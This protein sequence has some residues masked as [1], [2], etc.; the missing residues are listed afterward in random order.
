MNELVFRTILAAVSLVL[1]GVRA[2]Q[3]RTLG[4]L[5]TRG[6][7]V[8]KRGD[9]ISTPA[10][11]AVG[12]LAALAS[13][14]YVLAPDVIRWAALPL[15]AWLRWLGVLLGFVSIALF[16]WIHR[17]LG[18][19][20]AMPNVIKQDQT[21]VESGPYRWVRHPMY[22]MLFLWSLAFFLISAN[23][24]VGGLWLGMTLVAVAAST[25]E[26]AML[27]ERFGPAYRDYMR[28][29]GRFAPKIGRPSE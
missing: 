26:E 10:L 27:I 5:G 9:Q 6:A 1:L 19:N 14:I 20:W 13:I 8:L 2:Y 22:S 17:A 3:V 25:R 29:T 24:L 15:P 16:W 4:L 28:R 18:A 11:I 23:W 7:G 21:L 12:G